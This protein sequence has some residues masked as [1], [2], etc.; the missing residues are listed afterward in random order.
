MFID[1]VEIKRLVVDKELGAGDINGADA[2]G[3]S[4]NILVR[5]SLIS[6]TEANLNI[7]EQVSENHS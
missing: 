7:T 3:K 6:C 1:P 4:V 2:N 5:C